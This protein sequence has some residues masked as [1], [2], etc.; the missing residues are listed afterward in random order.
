MSI[1][2]VFWSQ[3]LL[4]V[5]F[6]HGSEGSETTCA[7]SHFTKTPVTYAFGDKGIKTMMNDQI[8]HM[9]SARLADRRQRTAD[10]VAPAE[11]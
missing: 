5:E 7:A 11:S 1:I 3:A 10:S 4:L 2:E 6:F 8:A 9:K